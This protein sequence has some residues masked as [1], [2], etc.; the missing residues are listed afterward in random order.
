MKD[1]TIRTKTIIITAVAIIAHAIIC[2]CYFKL[3]PSGG[4]M[5][6]G[7]TNL[8]NG[9]KFIVVAFILT[10][11]IPF[12]YVILNSYFS[13]YP[14]LLYLILAIVLTASC[15]A[16]NKICYDTLNIKPYTSNELQTMQDKQ[17][18]AMRQTVEHA[19]KKNEIY[20]APEKIM[21][22][23]KIHI[24]SAIYKQLNVLRTPVM[25]DQLKY[26]EVVA[27]LRRLSFGFF[28]IPSDSIVNSLKKSIQVSKLIY[29]PDLKNFIAVLTREVSTDPLNKFGQIK[30]LCHREGN[31]VY[32]LAFKDNILQIDYNTYSTREASMYCGLSECFFYSNQAGFGYH[33]LFLPKEQ[34]P[35]RAEFW[36]APR[37]VEFLKCK[38]DTVYK[39]ERSAINYTTYVYS[40]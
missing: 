24:L 9:I 5:G 25:Y 13:K 27:R 34:T 6:G 31:K 32:C 26:P 4:D 22:Q 20:A 30:L 39:D 17:V 40:N 15:F 8:V 29:S 28:E 38:T 12:L 19:F 36:M 7:M 23:D 1:E 14:F 35:P 11:L 16:N 3:M 33:E 18:Y 37:V 2:V 10:C 21:L